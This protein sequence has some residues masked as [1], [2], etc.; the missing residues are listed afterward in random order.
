LELLGA[1]EDGRLE[2]EVYDHNQLVIP[3]RLE[4]GVLDIRERNVYYVILLR[5]KS[6]TILMNL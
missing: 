1:D 5:D 3:A 4:E 6:N 2:V